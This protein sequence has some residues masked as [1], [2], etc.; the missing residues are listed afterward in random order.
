MVH[1]LLM[2]WLA[3]V[4]Q[5]LD[6]LGF[7]QG[8]GIGSASAAS[9]DADSDGGTASETVGSGWSSNESEEDASLGWDPNG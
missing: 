7:D 9:R 5:A 2:F 3:L 4:A 6:G 8:A 1:L